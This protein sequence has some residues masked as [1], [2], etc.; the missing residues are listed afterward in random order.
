MT[1]VK[2][3]AAKEKEALNDFIDLIRIKDKDDS[4]KFGEIKVNYES[5]RRELKKHNYNNDKNKDVDILYTNAEICLI[6][7]ANNIYNIG[8]IKEGLSEVLIQSS[9]GALL[10]YIATFFLICSRVN[11]DLK[12]KFQDVFLFSAVIGSPA[13]GY[14]GCKGAKYHIDNKGFTLAAD[15][16]VAKFAGES[17]LVE[18]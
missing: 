1:Q 15:E 10:G 13:G 8:D 12:S 6:D 7:A 9:V 17:E 3:C 4:H 5:L 2:T 14:L 11:L 16:C 18:I